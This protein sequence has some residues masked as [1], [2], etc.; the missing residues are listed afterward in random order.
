VSRALLWLGVFGA[1]AAWTVQL[2]AG[3]ALTQA[4]C[5]AAGWDV[6]MDAWTLAVSAV[7]V[8]VAVAAEA[9]ALLTFRATRDAGSEPPGARSRFLAVLGITI[10]P[11]FLAMIL[12]GGIGAVVL[13]QC[14]QG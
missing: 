13:V 11:L 4:E 12:M 2:V 3:F 8:V 6:H 14:R 5:G 7:A 10:G 1:P 9:A